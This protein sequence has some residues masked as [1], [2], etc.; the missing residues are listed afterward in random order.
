V[1]TF[2]GRDRMNVDFYRNNRVIVDL[3]EIQRPE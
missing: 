3:G 1:L 2:L